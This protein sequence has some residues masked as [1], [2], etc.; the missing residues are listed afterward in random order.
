EMCEYN[1]FFKHYVIVE[2]NLSKEI[3][4]TNAVYS[5]ISLCIANIFNNAFDAMQNSPQKELIIKTYMT[6]NYITL[7]ITDSGHGI[8]NNKLDKIFNINYT[9]KTNNKNS[10]Y[11]LGLALTKTI[12]EKCNGKIEVESQIEKGTT[13]KL[14]FPKM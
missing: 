7:Q 8:P 3:K 10:G 5:D 13:F 6:D 1:L 9:S 2:K 12:I 11:G 14:F 4:Y